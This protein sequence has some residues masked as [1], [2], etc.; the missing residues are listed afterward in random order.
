[1][2]AIVCTKYGAPE[3][4]QLQEVEKPVPKDNEVLIKVHAATATAAGLSGRKG[5]PFFARFF[6]GFTKPK[7]NILGMELAG[8]I[9]AVGKAAKLF[10]EVTKFLDSAV[11]V[12]ALMPSTNVCLKMRHCS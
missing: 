7:K 8:E 5:E 3:V 4:L 12:L 6:T 2:K 9:E 10:K 11:S 1:M